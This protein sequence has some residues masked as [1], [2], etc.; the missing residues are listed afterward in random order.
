MFFITNH[1]IGCEGRGEMRGGSAEI[2]QNHDK[3]AEGIKNES[4]EW[5]P[6]IFNYT[7]T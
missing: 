4:S 7:S 2:T 6:P 5:T 3:G 1:V